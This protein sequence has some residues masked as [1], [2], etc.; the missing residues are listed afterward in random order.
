MKED[1]EGQRERRETGDAQDA[2]YPAFGGPFGA[3]RVQGAHLDF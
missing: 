3:G 1:H 2:E